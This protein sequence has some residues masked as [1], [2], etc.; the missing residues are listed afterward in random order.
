MI[1]LP[2]VELLLEGNNTY[3]HSKEG[4]FDENTYLKSKQTCP[5]NAYLLPFSLAIL[6]K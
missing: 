3:N 6:P 1:I 2:V 5:K 4:S